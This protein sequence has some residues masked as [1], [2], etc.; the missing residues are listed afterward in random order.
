[1]I[2]ITD[3]MYSV[4]YSY[5]NRKNDND[6]ADSE[7]NRGDKQEDIPVHQVMCD[8]RFAFVTKTDLNISGLY[9][10]GAIKYVMGER[11][12]TATAE[13]YSTRCFKAV[14]LHNP[15]MINV[16][17][18]Q[19]ILENFNLYVMCRNALDD[20]D[21]DPFNPGPGRMFCF[22]GEAKL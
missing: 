17:L 16:K 11:P 3:L 15:V 18:S 19:D 21:A 1:M 10:A 22:G 14:K 12:Q 2:F 7:F 6:V 4:S 5:V 20:Y 13:E 8:F 9:E